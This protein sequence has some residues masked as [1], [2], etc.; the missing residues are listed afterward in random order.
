MNYEAFREQWLQAHPAS[1]PQPPQGSISTYPDWLRNAIVAMFIASALISGAHT[2]PTI[3][4]GI[5]VGVLPNWVR[6]I[7]ALSGFVA[8]ELAIFV[9]SYARMKDAGNRTAS[10]LLIIVISIAVLSNLYSVGKALGAAGDIF[11]TIVSVGLGFGMPLVALLSGDRIAHLYNDDQQ[12]SAEAWREYREALQK[13]DKAINDAWSKAQKAL[14]DPDRQ[15]LTPSTPSGVSVR[16]DADSLQTR[17]A[18]YGYN[19]S[20]D[21]QQTVIKWLNEHPDDAKLGSRP[22]GKLVGVSHDTANKGRQ[23]WQR[24]QQ[25]AAGAPTNGHGPSEEQS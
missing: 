14:P 22:L 10:V 6:G 25:L 19:T 2:A 4:A 3:Y 1:I 24:Q 11:L 18:S 9:A 7:V 12:A 17:Q 8:V 23:E 15:V 5:E 21:G 13:M 16:S 20:A